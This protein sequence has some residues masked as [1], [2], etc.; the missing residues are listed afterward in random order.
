MREPLPK[1]APPLMSDR[2]YEHSDVAIR[3]LLLFL[4]TLAV[5]LLVVSGIVA[6]LF[7][8]FEDQSLV[9]DPAPAPLAQSSSPTPAPLLQVVPRQDLESFRRRELELLSATQW[10]D[11]DRGIARIPIDEALSITAENGLPEW[12]AVE[13]PEGAGTP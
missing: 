1:P 13:S 2:S 9:N 4:A 11:R 5:S 8:F 3:P 6:W 7:S 12:P 10:L